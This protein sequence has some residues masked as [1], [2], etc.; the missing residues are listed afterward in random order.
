MRLPSG[1][2]GRGT[3][4]IQLAGPPM[5]VPAIQLIE[6]MRV[7]P[8][9]I[10]PLLSGHSRRLRASCA[11][12]GHAWPGEPLFQAIR[13]HAAKLD[14]VH[15]Y[16][17]RLL[18][19]PNG[20]YSLESAI[21]AMTLPPV[22]LHLSPAAL[23]ADAFWL[24]HKTTHRP[25]YADAQAW[26]AQNPEFFDVVFCNRNDEVCEGS[27][28][29]LYIQNAAGAWLTPPLACGLLPGVQRQ[30]LLDDGRVQEARI[31]RHDLLAAK[32]IRISNALRGWLAATL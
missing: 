16:R 20:H 22:R 28:S 3:A 1:C 30:A 15:N 9:R 10:I 32:A 27:R 8:G 31:T 11:A 18:L 29:N 25:W 19:D 26:L 12:L 2:I 4:A 13:Q 6:T 24:Q 14:A 7:E 21:L 5:T 23:E 17:L